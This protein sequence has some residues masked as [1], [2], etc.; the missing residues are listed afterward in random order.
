MCLVLGRW[1]IATAALSARDEIALTYDTIGSGGALRTRI[2]V[3]A[4]LEQVTNVWVG[5]NSVVGQILE[6]QFGMTMALWVPIVVAAA[7]LWLLSRRD[8]VGMAKIPQ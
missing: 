6:R 5:E 1:S 8:H 7:C 4:W 3:M 2:S